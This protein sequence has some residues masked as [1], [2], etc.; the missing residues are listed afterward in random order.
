MY[1]SSL[2]E[3]PNHG[4]SGDLRPTDTTEQP[5][6]LA[7]QFTLAKAEVRVQGN[8]IHPARPGAKYS[9]SQ[10]EGDRGR[11][12]MTARSVEDRY[13]ILL[14]ASSAM[15][16]QPTVTDV[17]HS[18]R[19]V[20]SNISC[21]YSAELYLLTEGRKGLKLFA[22]DRDA[23]G[24]AVPIGTEV[25][26]THSFARAVERQ[27]RV[28]LPDVA[29]EMLKFQELAPFAS[30][31]GKRSSYTFPVATSRKQ[32]G[33]VVFTA[34]QGRDFADEDLELMGS[35]AS[36]IAVAVENWVYQQQLAEERERLRASHDELQRS[37]AYLA[38]AQ[39]LSHTGSFAFD[40]TSHKYVYMSE[41]C[42]RIFEF[43]AQQPLPSREAL[44]RLIHAEDWDR[45]REDFEKLL[46]DKVDTPT[47][48]RIVLP[49]ATLRYV[50]AIRHPVLNDAG[51]VVQVVGTVMDIT[52]QKERE[53]ALQRSE[54]YLAEA[55]RLSHTASWAWDPANLKTSYWSEE[56]YRIFGLKPQDAPPT[57]DAFW[58]RIH[59]EDLEQM[60]QLIT[61]LSRAGHDYQHEHRVVQ[62]DG[63]VKYI[64]AIGHPVFDESGHL[65]E[66]LGTAI[67]ITE[68]QQAEEALRES[69]AQL[70]RERD[71]LSLLLE[72]N[73]YIA[74]ELE[75]DGL[76]KAVS[77]SM[78]AH[79]GCDATTLWL[80]NKDSGC[81]ERKYIDF[82]SGAGFLKKVDV[83]IPGNLESAW[84]R[85]RAPQFYSIQQTPDLPP[86]LRDAFEAE[87][88]VS[89]VSV[90]L[91]GASGPLG[92]M[93]ISSRR[94]DAFGEAD[95]DLLSQ[96][97]TQ[98]SLALDNALAYG[99][100]RASRDHLE[101]QRI[102]LES[103]ISSEYSFEDI[104]G[105]SSAL[106]RVLQQ[107]AVVARTDSTVLLHGETGTGKELI[108]RAIH[109]LSS[110]LKRP[111]IRMNCAAIPSGLLESE[112]FGHEKGAF[113]G[114]L[115]QRR[116]RFELADHGTLFLDEIG[117]ISLD[118]QPKL[119]RAVQE[120][121]FERLG[122]AKTIRVDVRIIA[123]THRDLTA[124]I[125]EGK[126]RQDL[127]YRLNVF[128]IEIPP[129]RERRE[130][131]PL[132][133]SHLVG[134]L[135]R[136]IGKR[137]RSISPQ[138][139]DILSKNPWPGNV[140]ELA[141]VLERA[142]ILTQGDEL[143]LPMEGHECTSAQV[144]TRMTA[145]VQDAERTMIMD[146]L[147]AS[148]GRVSGQG[149]AAERL[150]VKRTT[151]QNKMRRLG[152]DLTMNRVG[153]AP[154][155]IG[156]PDKQ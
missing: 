39:R 87:S 66:Y 72:I 92:F 84:W 76:F 58:E 97:G 28:Y 120:Q 150:G 69:K 90:P 112:L 63:T 113:T 1:S 17:L 44:S 107:V 31:V 102:Y 80:I 48:F 12:P 29:Q 153:A 27:E 104:I 111:F 26:C 54:A 30:R 156:I 53:Q 148:A 74:S 34:E 119:L 88:L 124:M 36:H 11:V 110:R 10:A 135:S 51:E 35:L 95:R 137:I 130:D 139:M 155:K 140:R 149:G 57:P 100:M 141:N 61:S 125:G 19:T 105:K 60:H 7:Q 133:V 45:V 56:M 121:E 151:L 64:H 59:P 81:L 68:R 78:R 93:N 75:V 123:A 118:L 129:L 86:A 99:R 143:E 138:S 73:N 108:A 89:R 71:R 116:G 85:T 6:R 42:L 16:D 146:A 117:D 98:I 9:H 114:A 106:K 50:R 14:R 37:E 70:A 5:L 43:D 4:D 3:S 131:I 128:P 127:F 46:R 38:E 94:A 145:A 13:R 132:L 25:P 136:R 96:I 122:S 115:M 8:E 40:V 103:E 82:P 65:I 2:P 32:Y 147:R 144:A 23:D 91:V 109:D 142:V 134:K 18:L 52:E 79:L 152:I 126:F 101:D 33:A 24:I 62:P 67:D 22:Y 83:V 77:A 21:V 15:A 55:E 20:L 41:E 49:S 154:A 47:D